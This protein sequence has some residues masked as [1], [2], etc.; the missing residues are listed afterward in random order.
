MTKAEQVKSIIESVLIKDGVMAKPIVEE[1]TEVVESQ[2][3][4]TADK[5]CGGKKKGK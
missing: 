3:K 5:K 2:E 1:V 4:E